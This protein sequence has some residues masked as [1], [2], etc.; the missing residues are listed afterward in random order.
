MS[1]KT[2]SQE[3]RQYISGGRALHQRVCLEEGLR[4]KALVRLPTTAIP[5]PQVVTR[6]VYLATFECPLGRQRLTFSRRLQFL[7]AQVAPSPPLP[8]SAA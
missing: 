7:V 1:P 8:R 6:E 4:R 2:S 5:C 3:Y